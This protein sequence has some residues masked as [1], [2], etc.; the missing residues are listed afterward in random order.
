MSEAGWISLKSRFDGFEFSA[1]RVPHQD[2][3]RGG[4]VLIQEI[5][6]VNAGL[7]A[8]AQEWAA[9]GYEVIAPSMFDRAEPRADY[10]PGKRGFAHMLPICQATPWDQAVGDV[11][12][13]LEALTPPRFIIGLCWGAAAGWAAAA[14]TDG[15]AAFSGFYGR[16]IIDLVE[17]APRCPTVLHFG[18]LDQSIP[19]DNAHAIAERHPDVAVHLYN[20][21]HGFL[22]GRGEGDQ[23]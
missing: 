21:D 11:Q 7:R 9:M 19:V 20:A 16:R 15:V 4:L 1:W 6:G 2:A 18:E 13:A 10:E 14:R 3:R 12:A 22:S 5:F 23:A 17:E 8:M